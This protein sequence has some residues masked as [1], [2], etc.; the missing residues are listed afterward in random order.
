MNYKWRIQPVHSFRKLNLGGSPVSFHFSSQDALCHSLFPHLCVLSS[1]ISFKGILSYS[2]YIWWTWI[3]KQ[4]IWYYSASHCF[5]LS[6][7]ATNMAQEWFFS[8][9]TAINHLQFAVLCIH[10]AILWGT[11]LEFSTSRNQKCVS[12]GEQRQKE[13][14]GKKKKRRLSIER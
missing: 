14:G 13:K 11:M 10:P 4:N 3:Q 12:I 6:G 1:C 5:Y 8:S 7:H 9:G 2:C